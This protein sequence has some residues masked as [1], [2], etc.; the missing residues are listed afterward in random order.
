MLL[1]SQMA[2]PKESACSAVGIE[3]NS[4]EA[5]FLK[6]LETVKPS[7][8]TNAVMFELFGYV[9]KRKKLSWK[10][11]R[12]V[13]ATIYNRDVQPTALR[14]SAGRV[15]AERINIMKTKITERGHLLQDYLGKQWQLPVTL[16]QSKKRKLEMCETDTLPPKVP[17]MEAFM[18]E[19]QKETMEKLAREST[20]LQIQLSDMTQENGRLLNENKKLHTQLLVIKQTLRLYNPKRV[21][22]A[23]KR[24]Q[25]SIASWKQKCKAL[26]KS[27]SKTTKAQKELSEKNVVTRERVQEKAK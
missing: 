25:N 15:K 14:N 18:Q 3:L 9:Q 10:D 26:A 13:F 1:F 6:S 23:L 4:S 22:Q 17:K 20:V 5:V 27:S 2:E 8:I 16:Q 12:N 24:K 11:V 21:N 7:Q 19:V